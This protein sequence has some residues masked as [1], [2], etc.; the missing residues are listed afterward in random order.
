MEIIR[1]ILFYLFVALSFIF[2]TL[3]TVIIALFE[4]NQTKSFQRS[5]KIWAKLLAFLS[6]IPVSIEGDI[7]KNEAFI[8][9][10][11]HQ[12]YADVLLLLA[13]LPAHFRFII[14][15]ELFKIPFFG[16]Y[17]KKAGFI[18]VDRG[19]S[20]KAHKLF[21]EAQD[22]I[23]SGEN[24]LIFPEGTRSNDGQLQP[25]KRGALLLAFKSKVK[26]IPIAISGSFNILPPK[27]LFFRVVPVKLKIGEPVSLERFG[28][29]FE[30][31]ADYIHTQ[32]KNM[33]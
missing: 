22:I 13:Y 25:F 8:L 17:L 12:S 28:S 31:A 2:G 10:S 18:S 9:A 20:E 33:L 23:K 14:K 21:S 30:E 4:K 19:S 3:L 24:I 29:K 32:I 16:W 11:N 6:G 5:A 15:K 7:L 26:V 1:S 27:S